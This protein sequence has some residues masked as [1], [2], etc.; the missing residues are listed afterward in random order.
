MARELLFLPGAATGCAGYAEPSE[1]PS[2]S[3][4]HST[5]KPLLSILSLIALAYGTVVSATVVPVS[6][7]HVGNVGGTGVFA[8]DLMGTGLS[9]IQSVKVTDNNGG[10]AGSS[11]IFSGFDL[12]ALF[13]DAD[14][15]LATTGDQSCASSFL[16]TAGSTRPTADPVLLPTA[17]HPGPT[18]GSLDASTVDLATATLNAVDGVSIADVNQANGFLTLG[19]GGVLTA[20]FAPPVGF[21]GSIFLMAGEVGDNGEGLDAVVTVSDTLQVPEPGSLSIVGFGLL[22][23][24]FAALR[25]R[26][27]RAFG[28]S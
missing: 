26:N 1:E 18:F 16:F 24:G 5:L 3:T 7:T 20:I 9:Q 22:L 14:G 4:S 11:G 12:D 6:F 21:S 8:A 23:I 15:N 17:A 28:K 2:M 10:T 27:N 25:R 19:D 13:L